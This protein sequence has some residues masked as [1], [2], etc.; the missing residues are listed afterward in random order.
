MNVFSYTHWIEPLALGMLKSNKLLFQHKDLIQ[1]F[2]SIQKFC[3]TKTN[4]KHNIERSIQIWEELNPGDP[5]RGMSITDDQ[6]S[7]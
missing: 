6:I 2:S 5:T 7:W 3:H 1:T 4:T